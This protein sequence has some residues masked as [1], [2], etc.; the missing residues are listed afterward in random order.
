MNEKGQNGIEELR[1]WNEKS[2]LVKKNIFNGWNP[3]M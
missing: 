3:T 1:T 2:F